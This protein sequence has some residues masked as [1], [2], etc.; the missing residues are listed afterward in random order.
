[1]SECGVAP[2]PDNFELFYIYSTGGNP[3]LAQVMDST[4]SA[5]KPFTSDVLN[6]LRG[7]CL[8]SART[9]QALDNAS[10]SV[11]RP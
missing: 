11:A 5:R 9:A 10:L 1:M 8:S 7:R 3:D 6:D 4:I 2:T